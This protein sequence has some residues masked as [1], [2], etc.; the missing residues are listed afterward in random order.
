M[1]SAMHAQDTIVW[2]T[3]FD[4]G[5]PDI[6]EQHHMLVSTLNDANLTL[7]HESRREVVDRL[8]EDL[9]AYALYH[10]ETEEGLM[11]EHHYAA[12]DARMAATH[13]E[14]HRRFAQRVVAWRNTL[15]RTGDVDRDALLLFLNTWLQQH[16]LGIDQQFARFLHERG[17]AG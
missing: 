17:A 5:V 7:Q 6:D 10:F 14:E 9:L 15:D 12:H 16:I 8:L 11:L 13:I 3:G 2:D 1:T 4:T